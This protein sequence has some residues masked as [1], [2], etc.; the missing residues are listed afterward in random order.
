MTT[1]TARQTKAREA[2]EKATNE[3]TVAEKKLKIAKSDEDKAAA[4]KVLDTA[5]AKLA[6]AQDRSTT[7]DEAAEEAAAKKAAKEAERLEKAKAKAAEKE[8][9]EKAKAEAK[10][11][12]QMP[13]QNGIRQPKDGTATGKVWAIATGLSNQKGAPATAKEVREAGLAEGINPATIATQYNRW[14]KFHGITGRLVTEDTSEET[15]ETSE[16]AE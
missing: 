15:K 10:A 14:R 9:K 12:N 3:V 6:K 2:V 11:A 1:L 16:S 7:A 4:Q 8:A 13:E 5:K